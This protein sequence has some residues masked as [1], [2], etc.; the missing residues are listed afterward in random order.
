MSQNVVKAEQTHK[1]KGAVGGSWHIQD[2]EVIFKTRENRSS[3]PEV[4]IIY[5]RRPQQ[6]D[7]TNRPRS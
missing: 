3:R 5:L 2:T 7:S 1:E 4:V 6:D